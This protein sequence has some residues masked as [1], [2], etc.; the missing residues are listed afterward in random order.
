MVLP[1]TGAGCTEKQSEEK[2]ATKAFS[3]ERLQE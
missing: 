2:N 3:P 1:D